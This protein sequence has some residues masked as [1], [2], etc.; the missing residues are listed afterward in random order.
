MYFTGFHIPAKKPTNEPLSHPKSTLVWVLFL[1]S[2]IFKN[3]SRRNPEENPN[4]T[5]RKLKALWNKPGTK[6]GE[7]TP[8]FGKLGEMGLNGFNWV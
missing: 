8:F 2:T 5:R 4:K 7:N 6:L 1:K 3:K